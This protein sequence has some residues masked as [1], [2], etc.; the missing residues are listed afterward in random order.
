[1]DPITFAITVGIAII[2]LIFLFLNPKVAVY[3]LLFLTIFD[4]GFFSRWFDFT[5]HLA[6]LPFFVA[7]LLSLKIGFD[8]TMNRLAISPNEKIVRKSKN[9]FQIYHLAGHHCD[10]FYNIQSRKHPIGII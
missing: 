10:H 6:R 9:C 5:R 1:M 7:M 2:A 8:Y 3:V 4:L